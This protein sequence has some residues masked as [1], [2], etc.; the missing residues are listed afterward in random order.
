MA[1]VEQRQ[2][3]ADF[4]AA[5][6]RRLVRAVVDEP[7]LQ[8][9]DEARAAREFEMPGERLG[10]EP[11]HGEVEAGVHRQLF[12]LGQRRQPVRQPGQALGQFEPR[13]IGQAQRRMRRS[14]LSILVWSARATA[15][16]VSA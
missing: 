13:G 6:T 5:L 10:V 14:R 12:D 9:V 8:D 2:L 16:A 4:V 1:E 7:Q 11:H 3:E 15:S